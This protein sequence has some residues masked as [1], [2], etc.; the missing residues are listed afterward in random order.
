VYGAGEDFAHLAEIERLLDLAP[1]AAD[2]DGG[3]KFRRWTVADQQDNTG[4][5]KTPIVDT[6]NTVRWSPARGGARSVAKLVETRAPGDGTESSNE[7]A[8][9]MGSIPFASRPA[10][11]G[12]VMAIASD[13]PFPGT[14]RDWTWIFNS[15]PESHWKWFQRTGFSLQRTNNDYWK[16]LIP[17]VGEAPVVSFILLVSLFAV[18]IGPVNYLLLGRARR[19]YLLLITVPAGAAV[20]TIGLFAFALLSDG[21]GMRLRIRSYADLEQ[22]TGRAAVWSRHSYYA[23]M[24]PSQGLI[25]PDDATVFP[26]AHEPSARGEDRTTLLAWDGDQ[27]L[28]RG[29]LSSRTATQYMICRATTSKAQLVVAEGKEPGQPPKVENRLGTRIRY[30][31]LRDGRGGYFA[32]ELVQDKATKELSKV[33]PPTAAA[34]MN[35]SAAADWPAEPHGYDPQKHNDYTFLR[36]GVRHLRMAS[37]DSA[38]ADPTMWQSLLEENINQALNSHTQPLERQTYVAIVETSPLVITGVPWAREESS[39]HVIRGRY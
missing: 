16:I 33:D 2:E 23:G 6:G 27:Q 7:T 32:G 22:Q 5:L 24:A 15:V 17:G 9:A 4:V 21:L 35:M 37:S 12:R 38:E 19:L 31:L 20:V 28:R 30:V 34:A 3:E 13:K 18:L 25:F 11:M 29:F 1:L 8:F 14:Q 36:L 39:F 10:K 26:I